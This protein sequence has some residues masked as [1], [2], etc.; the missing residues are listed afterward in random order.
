[1][2][3]LRKYSIAG[4]GRPG[5]FGRG[6]IGVC[7]EMYFIVDNTGGGRYN[8]F[9]TIKVQNVQPFLIKTFL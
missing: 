7:S 4:G 2:D 8:L 1:M 5:L 9:G 6:R 3:I